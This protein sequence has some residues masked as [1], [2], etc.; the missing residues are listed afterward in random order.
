[1]LVADGNGI[2]IG[3]HLDS[4]SPAEVKL[5]ASTLQTVR[6]RTRNGQVKTRPHQ[7]LADRAYDS[8]AF[9]AR[10]RKRGIKVCIPPRRRPKTGAK[11]AAGRSLPTA[12][13]TSN[14]SRLSAALPGWATIGGC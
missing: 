1:M 8:R 4:A 11:S 12:K 14:A 3:F 13:L 9:R 2:P 7:L 6:V 5:A 10:L